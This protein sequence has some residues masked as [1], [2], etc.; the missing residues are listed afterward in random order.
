[1]M[2]KTKEDNLHIRRVTIEIGSVRGNELTIDIHPPSQ[3]VRLDSHWPN[4]MFGHV[5]H[6]S[7]DTLIEHL[8]TLI[9]PKHKID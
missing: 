9:P 7:L 4:G 6:L 3:T 2:L 8:R 1:M 5:N